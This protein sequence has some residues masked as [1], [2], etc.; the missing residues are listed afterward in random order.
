[1]SAFRFLSVS[2]CVVVVTCLGAASILAQETSGTISGSVTDEQGQV[3][4]GATVTAVNERTSY[5]RAGVDVEFSYL[6][7]IEYQA[8]GTTTRSLRVFGARSMRVML[9]SSR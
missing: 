5:S 4:P 9:N 3:L 6:S 7:S 1:M 2:L 8:V